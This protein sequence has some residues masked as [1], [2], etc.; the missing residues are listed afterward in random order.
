MQGGRAGKA[1]AIGSWEPRARG[2]FTKLTW[3]KGTLGHVQ[4]VALAV[5]ACVVCVVVYTRPPV[6]KRA[7]SVG[8]LTARPAEGSCMCF[9]DEDVTQE[10]TDSKGHVDTRDRTNAGRACVRAWS[11]PGRTPTSC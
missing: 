4:A 10:P 1:L 9:Q 6:L 11:V 3:A 5:C 8:A 7:G 2:V